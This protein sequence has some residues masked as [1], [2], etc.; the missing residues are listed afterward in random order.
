MNVLCGPETIDHTT[1]TATVDVAR[2][3]DV[4]LSFS[5]AGDGW[6]P[7]SSIIYEYMQNPK[8]TYEESTYKTFLERC[9]L[10]STQELV[11]GTDQKRMP[12][13]DRGWTPFPW[14]P[15]R[16]PMDLKK[17]FSP[18]AVVSPGPREFVRMIRLYH[19]LKNEGYLPDRYPDGYIRGYFLRSRQDYRFHVL[20]GNHRMAVIG[21][22][23]YRTIKV[24]IQPIG[25]RPV[26]DLH[27]VDSVIVSSSGVKLARAS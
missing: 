4:W 5:Y 23:G 25:G 14:F 21:M 11:F 24:K 15:G 10:R 19:K 22:L 13:M 2:C 18:E 20:G 9:H 16:R 6:N 26:V 12:P 7:Y 1:Q 17:N 3:R 8:L 27:G